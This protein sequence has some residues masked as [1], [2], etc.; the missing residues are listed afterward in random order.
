MQIKE[1]EKTEFEKQWQIHFYGEIHN[2]RSK[3]KLLMKDWFYSKFEDFSA[4]TPRDNGDW[5]YIY[6]NHNVPE[7]IEAMFSGTI[8]DVIIQDVIN[9]IVDEIGIECAE[10]P[11]DLHYDQVEK[12]DDKSSM[13]RIQ[14]NC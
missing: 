11:C 4:N 2:I 9:D 12:I 1:S 10:V 3:I 13:G 8:D 7:V 14:K 5:V 6:G